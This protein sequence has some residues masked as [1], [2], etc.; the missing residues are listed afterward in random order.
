LFFHILEGRGPTPKSPSDQRTDDPV[1]AFSYAG[2]SLSVRGPILTTS[3]P[4][5]PSPIGSEPLKAPT[6]QDVSLA[7]GEAGMP[8]PGSVGRPQTKSG[9]GASWVEQ[10]TKLADEI[11]LWHYSAKTPRSYMGWVRAL[12]SFTKS[13][14]PESL[15]PDDVKEFLTSLAVRRKV[16]SST[17][18]QAFN[19]LLFFF[20]R[21]E[22]AGCVIKA[23]TSAPSIASRD[24]SPQNFPGRFLPFS[25]C[26]G[27]A[28]VCI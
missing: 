3:S 21:G 28:T 18:N 16:S 5:I 10:Y 26:W 6:V 15:S 27:R 2:K 20:R 9:K 13:K 8:D 11:Q 25:G 19:A 23:L 22:H 7:V 1:N 4:G 14:P 24:P 17:Q 12:Q